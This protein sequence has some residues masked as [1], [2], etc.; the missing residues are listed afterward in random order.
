M[1]RPIG[2]SAGMP[3]CSVRRPYPPL[4]DVGSRSVRARAVNEFRNVSNID[5]YVGYPT[6][7]NVPSPHRHRQSS[8][9]ESAACS[10]LN[11]ERTH[12]PI[13]PGTIN[14]SFAS[15]TA[16]LPEMRSSSDAAF[17]SADRVV[18]L[19]PSNLRMPEMRTRSLADDR[20]RPDAIQCE[21]LVFQRTWFAAVGRII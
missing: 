15:R 3:R 9:T 16:P 20:K 2:A 21:R 17:K 1:G 6:C 18:R 7:E 4:S 11:T 13:S 19:R 12:A 5:H 10:R 14:V 8:V